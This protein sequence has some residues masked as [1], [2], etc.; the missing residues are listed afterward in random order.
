MQTPI[1]ERAKHNLFIATDSYADDVARAPSFVI[2]DPFRVLAHITEYVKHLA[3]GRTVIEED[4]PGTTTCLHV[5]AVLGIDVV[6]LS[7]A[8]FASSFLQEH[9][10]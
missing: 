8:T 1:F 10:F 5:H 9:A 3:D 2:Q 4:I 7:V 6:A